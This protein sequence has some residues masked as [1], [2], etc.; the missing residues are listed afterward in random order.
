MMKLGDIQQEILPRLIDLDFYVTSSK[1]LQQ[2]L[3]V[4]IKHKVFFHCCLLLWLFH[5]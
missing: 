2:L 1:L 3:R 4:V 5:R